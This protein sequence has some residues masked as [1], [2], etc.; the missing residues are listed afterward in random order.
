MGCDLALVRSFLGCLVFRERE[1]YFCGCV[2][3]DVFRF[4]I[5]CFC[6]IKGI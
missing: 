6:I 2:Y 3:F 4:V 1:R 5:F